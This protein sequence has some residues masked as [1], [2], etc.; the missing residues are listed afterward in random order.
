[1]KMFSPV[2]QAKPLPECG[3]W[4]L[5]SHRIVEVNRIDGFMVN[6]DR[7]TKEGGIEGDVGKSW[8][9]R[10]GEGWGEQKHT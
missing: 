2:E 3:V 5:S 9:K 4:N 7:H 6:L 8:M 1:M 10:L